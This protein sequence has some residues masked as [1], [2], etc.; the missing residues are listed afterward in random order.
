MYGTLLGEISLACTAMILP[1]MM[2]FGVKNYFHY[3]TKPLEMGVGFVLAFFTVKVD[4]K[5]GIWQGKRADWAHFYD[6]RLSLALSNFFRDE[7]ASTIVDLGCGT[8]DYVKDL[9]KAKLTC[10]GFDGNPETPIITGGV[11]RV[12][13]LT[14]P[15]LRLNT[16]G[17][18]YDWVVSLEVGEH[19][20]KEH[21]KTFLDN[22]VKHARN[23]I[24]L[25][26]AKK[27]QG[28]LGHVNEQNN[29]YIEAKLLERNW[30]RDFQA[31]ENLR[32]STSPHCFWFRDTIM[33]YRPC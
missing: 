30:K 22:I 26:W 27:G 20:P 12:A 29:D 16:L 9:R 21:E 13:D 18:K 7:K 1:S 28:G 19:L 2:L 3:I 8:G 6:G 32:L 15:R 25:S 10:D 17:G 33:V 31:E 14:K 11:C 5:T 23:G 4:P 24:V